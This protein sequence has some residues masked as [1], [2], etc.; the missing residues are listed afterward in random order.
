MDQDASVTPA[1]FT[2]PQE[3]IATFTSFKARSSERALAMTCTYLFSLYEQYYEKKIALVIY[4]P[5]DEYSFFSKHFKKLYHYY[6]SQNSR[7]R[8]K[9]FPIPISHYQSNNC[10]TP[11]LDDQS[12]NCPVKILCLRQT[13]NLPTGLNYASINVLMAVCHLK[14]RKKFIVDDSFFSK[15]QNL[16]SVMLENSHCQGKLMLSNLPLLELISV[17]GYF[18]D[19]YHL[20]DPLEEVPI[21]QVDAPHSTLVKSLTINYEP[22]SVKTK[23]PPLRHLRELELHKPLND[24]QF[25]ETSVGKV[26]KLLLTWDFICRYK[27]FEVLSSDSDNR[28]GHLRLLPFTCLKKLYIIHRFPTYNLSYTFSFGIESVIVISIWPKFFHKPKEVRTFKS[29]PTP[30]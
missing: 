14:E 30:Q 10:L 5:L 16:K 20:V 9:F 15:F 26:E 4:N 1:I 27:G 28:T 2:I 6:M 8:F 7:I 11:I 29:K 21:L 12:E 17:H 13:S 3:L 19:N 22:C 23:L 18:V 24:A 25:F